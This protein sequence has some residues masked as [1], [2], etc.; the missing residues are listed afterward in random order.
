MDR[1]R[2]VFRVLSASALFVIGA[3]GGE[4]GDDRA[5]HSAGETRDETAFQPGKFPIQADAIDDLRCAIGG[6]CEGT[7]T[8]TTANM[9]ASGIPA[10]GDPPLILRDTP[11][12]Y[13]VDSYEINSGRVYYPREA[14]A[15]FA[16]LSL[17]G[18]FLNSGIEML[19][20]GEFYASWGIVT[21]ITWTGIF[22]TPGLRGWALAS[23]IDEL[24]QENQ[25]ARSPIYQKMSGRYGTSGYSFGGG[26][27]TVASQ[28]DS[29]LKVSIG[30]APWAPTGLGVETPSLFMCGDVDV[31]A[32]CDMSEWAYAE[33]SE[34][35]PKMWVMVSGGHLA[36]FGPDAGW[37]I[38]GAFG[39]AF[40]K[41][42]LE[43]DTRWRATLLGLD[44]IVETNIY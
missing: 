30:M 43:G 22:D 32:G 4:G 18:G 5:T 28:A 2:F 10:H 29:S 23:A 31:V 12:P 15:P 41:L 24:K 19:G 36:W 39:L 14:P 3:C 40:A 9:G 21:V 35:V 11:G 17:C 42:F 37:G 13:W 7:N 25:N 44:G 38:G 20:W 34:S 27:A 33:L 8:A 16:G 6:N 26:G 1:E